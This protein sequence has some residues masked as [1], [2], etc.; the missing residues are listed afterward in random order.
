MI[1]KGV[2]GNKSNKWGRESLTMLLVVPL[3]MEESLLPHPCALL[4]LLPGIEKHMEN[5]RGIWGL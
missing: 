3:E 2:T 4:R 1:W 5:T